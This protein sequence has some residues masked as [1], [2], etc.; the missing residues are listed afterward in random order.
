MNKG[1]FFTNLQ[2][3]GPRCSQMLSANTSP[4]AP[5]FCGHPVGLKYQSCQL[6]VIL[7][8]I[9]SKN[10]LGKQI[11]STAGTTCFHQQLSTPWALHT[12]IAKS[13]SFPTRTPT[14]GY[15]PLSYAVTAVQGH[16]EAGSKTNLD[17]KQTNQKIKRD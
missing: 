12:G 16:C 8:R 15:R 6:H 9:L 3:V 17:W 11:L 5:S 4:S 10:N 7:P 1:L 2:S 14:T 13:S